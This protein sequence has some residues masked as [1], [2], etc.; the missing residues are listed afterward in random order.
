MQEMMQKAAKM[1]AKYARKQRSGALGEMPE[2]GRLQEES[3]E[4]HLRIN[5]ES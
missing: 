4:L 5:A 3:G 1:Q 2:N